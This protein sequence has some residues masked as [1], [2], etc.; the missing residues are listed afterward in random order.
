MKTPHR[1][2]TSAP[3]EHDQTKRLDDCQQIMRATRSGELTMLGWAHGHYPGRKLP[4]HILPGLNTVGFWNADHE[5]DWAT[6]IHCNEGIELTYVENGQVTLE[7]EG[8]SYTLSA[9]DLSA[10]RP[11]QTH[12]LGAPHVGPTRVHWFMLDVGVQRAAERWRWPDWILLTPADRQE[13]ARRLNKHENPVYHA[14]SELRRC[15]LR[16]AKI[17]EAED[18]ESEMTLMSVLVNEALVLL[19]QQLRQE[20]GAEESHFSD[21]TQC[22]AMFWREVRENCDQLTREWTL[23]GMARR[24][25]LGVT[26]FVHVTKRQ[27]NLTPLQYLQRCRVEYAAK[28]LLQ[29]RAERIIDVAMGCGFSSGQYFARCFRRR[30]ACS[31]QVFRETHKDETGI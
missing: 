25:G 10:T 17:V 2:S 31:P 11:W 30:F 18:Y 1:K 6:G 28:Q 13:F 4:S 27:F 19:L 16:I 5:Q 9:D 7:V 22:V 26:Q 21:S 12:R 23:A 8:Q 29:R 20:A 14:G 24:C 3:E 15:F